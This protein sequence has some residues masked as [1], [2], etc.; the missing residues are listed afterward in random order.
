MAE[1]SWRRFLKAPIFDDEEKTR[2]GRALHTFLWVLLSAT[3]LAYLSLLAAAAPVRVIAITGLLLIEIISFILLRHGFV[4]QATLTLCVFTWIIL[5]IALAL[6]GGVDGPSM[7]IQALIVITA[8]LLLGGP[9]GLIFASLG[10]LVGLGMLIAENIGVLP[11]PMIEINPGSFWL[12]LTITLFASAGLIYVTTN[13]LNEAIGRARQN[14]AAQKATNIKLQAVQASLEQ[15]VFER[16]R[17]LEQRS[18]YL[19]AAIEISRASASILDPDQLFQQTVNLIQDQFGLYYVGLFLLDNEGE[20]A[21]LK[22]GTGQAGH[23]LLQRGHRIRVNTGMIGWC[24][25]NASARVAQ[26]AADDTQRL[27]TA[28]L[29]ETRS[30]AA[31]P[32][33]SRGKTLGAISVQSNIPQAF[34]DVEITSFQAMADQVALAIDNTQLLTQAQTAIQAVERAYGIASRLA[35]SEMLK[36]TRLLSYRYENG[37]VTLVEQGKAMADTK[38]PGQPASE[39]HRLDVPIKVRERVIG[40]LRLHHSAI[41]ALPADVND[42]LQD[43]GEQ[44]GIALESARLYQE[45][46]RLALREQLTSEVTSRIRETLDMETVIKTAAQEIQQALGVPEVVI[47]LQTKKI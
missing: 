45:S 2:T 19:Q 30:E 8:G 16:T 6:T 9:A 46:Q 28:E 36:S 20:W 42:M 24:I 43:L 7:S 27:A 31:I 35:W 40:H 13:S 15:Q 32:L 38:E 37:N 41:P 21:V 26:F 12:F 14:E 47:T 3:I 4:R 18:R 22:A 10:T 44:L 17:S 29:P 33:R 39:S 11:A 23:F 25:A 34:G 1:A 5:A